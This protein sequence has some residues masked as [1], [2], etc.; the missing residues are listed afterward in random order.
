MVLLLRG[1]RGECEAAGAYDPDSGVGSPIGTGQGTRLASIKN[2]LT[3]KV[4]TQGGGKTLYR[5]RQ[6]QVNMILI[7]SFSTQSVGAPR[8]QAPGGSPH[9]RSAAILLEDSRTGKSTSPNVLLLQEGRKPVSPAGYMGFMGGG[10]IA[11]LIGLAGA[12]KSFTESA[13][14]AP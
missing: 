14:A 2:G 6:G 5:T 4:E 1:A 7:A 3:T 10:A 13:S 8:L 11:V 9:P 12:Y